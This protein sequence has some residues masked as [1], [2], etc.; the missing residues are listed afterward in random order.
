M[1]RNWYVA[2]S[3]R[4]LL[5]HDTACN[6]PHR[7]I[8][9]GPLALQARQIERASKEKDLIVRAWVPD[10]GNSV[11]PDDIRNGDWW[12]PDWCVRVGTS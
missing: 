8:A 12:E 7:M 4:M 9:V 11:V 1:L 10:S 3:V 6:Q 2:L 5:C